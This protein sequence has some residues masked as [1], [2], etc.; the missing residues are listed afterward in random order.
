MFKIDKNVEIPENKPFMQRLKYPF[1]E[2]D[3]GDSFF[4]SAKSREDARKIQSR[5]SAYG[6]KFSLVYG[7]KFSTR[8]VEED[9]ETGVRV[10]RVE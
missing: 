4:I 1:A 6:T 9:G 10:W 8:T 7:T 3:I 5:V 2:M